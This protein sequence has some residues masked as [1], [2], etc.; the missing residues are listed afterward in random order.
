MRAGEFLAKKNPRKGSQLVKIK[1]H[2]KC[3]SFDPL[4]QIELDAYAAMSAG[5]RTQ[6]DE[7]I[8]RAI[9]STIVGN[10][11]GT[12][13]ERTAAQR[14]YDEETYN[15]MTPERMQ[16]EALMLEGKTRFCR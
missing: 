14:E 12:T 1:Y 3:L 13:R 7:D 9:E 4:T 11:V 10:V 8:R 15:V 2:A 16:F 6:M 5:L